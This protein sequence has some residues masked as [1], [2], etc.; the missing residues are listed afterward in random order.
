MI[1]LNMFCYNI[2]KQQKYV[3]SYFNL[4][5]KIQQKKG[6]RERKQC[7]KLALP[8]WPSSLVFGMSLPV[9]R[10]GYCLSLDV[11]VSYLIMSGL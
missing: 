6:G 1:Q 4:A 7:E 9:A 8:P 5:A 11:T 10:V 3:L 2:I